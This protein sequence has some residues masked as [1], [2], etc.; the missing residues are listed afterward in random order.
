MSR[1]QV[2]AREVHHCK[3]LIPLFFGMKT[4]GVRLGEDG[5]GAQMSMVTVDLRLYTENMTLI[6]NS[7]ARRF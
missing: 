7:Y 3:G 1:L 6:G 5:S 4:V 2:R